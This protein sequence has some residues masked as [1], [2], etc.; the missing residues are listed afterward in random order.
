MIKKMSK[1]KWG[2]YTEDGS[3]LLG[4]HGSEESARKQLQAIEISKHQHD[5]GATKPRKKQLGER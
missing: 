4:E 5:K 2:V 1:S 3:R